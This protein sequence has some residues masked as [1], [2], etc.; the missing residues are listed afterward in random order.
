[1]IFH[2]NILFILEPKIPDTAIPFVDDTSIKG[3]T[4]RYETKDGGY[5]TIPANLQIC[6]FIWE[7]LNDVHRILYHFL[8]ASATVSTKK[9]AIA[10]P[11]VTIL[12]HKCNYEGHIPND[13]KITKIRDWPKCKS[14]TD[15]HTFLGITG[16]MHIWIKNYSS[17]AQPLV[18]LTCKAILFSWQEQHAQAMQSLKNAIVQSTALISIDYTTDHTIYLSVDLSVYSIGWILT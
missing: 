13:S 17:I 12:G 3:P 1:M 6:H 7:H 8:Y 16:Y 9:I 15:V 4:T 14:L 11:E 5:E 18:N 10:V 2:G